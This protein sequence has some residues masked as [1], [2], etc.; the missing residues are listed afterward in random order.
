V[1]TLNPLES[2]K[3]TIDN[4]HGWAIE[5]GH[6][7]STNSSGRISSNTT[8]TN[9]TQPVIAEVKF[10]VSI[11]AASGF[12]ANGWHDGALSG[13]G[14]LPHPPAPNLHYYRVGAAWVGPYN[15]YTGDYVNNWAHSLLSL[16]G[17]GDA[18]AVIQRYPDKYSSETRNAA[19]SITDLPIA[20]GARYDNAAPNQSHDTSWDWVFVR[21]Y[22]A[23]EPVITPG[24]ED[25]SNGLCPGCFDK[26]ITVDNSRGSAQTAFQI[27]VE[28]D[29]DHATFW[30][31][32]TR[33]GDDI[34]F[35]DGETE[36]DYWIEA[37][38]S[39]SGTIVQVATGEYFSCALFNSGE[40]SCWGYNGQGQL[41]DGTTTNRASAVTVQTGET[42]TGNLK[43]VDS[44]S[45]NNRHACA[46]LN[47][48]GNVVC[49]GY[50]NQGQLG[51]NTTTSHSTP[52]Y[53]RSANGQ[54]RLS[55]IV[56]VSVGQ[57]HTCA[58]DGVRQVYCWGDDYLS[59][60]GNGDTNANDELYPVKV[61]DTEDIEEDGDG[62]LNTAID[63]KAGAS[64]T[65]AVLN[66]GK[67]VCWGYDDYEGL[68][69]N[70]TCGSDPDRACLVLNGEHGFIDITAGSSFSCGV[71]PDGGVIYWGNNDNGKLGDGTD[72]DRALAIPMARRIE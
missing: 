5:G 51:N 10:R 34:R 49:W 36:L 48:D 45:A 15:T 55:N 52:V 62:V 39:M 56:K 11:L 43:D 30:D 72:T 65:C 26:A 71:R 23:D 17:A 6:L 41:G 13:F 12:M 21:K 2:G 4:P 63:V 33:G 16:D 54:G 69:D 25:V 50:N 42:G 29:A 44:I 24:T 19:Y 38:G 32:V 64:H 61:V 37:T 47:P 22:A 8:F 20:L 31:N 58:I 9:S 3:W 40:V 53:V 27:K 7:R 67:T 59:R 14:L 35:Y 28:L 18:T 70:G 1:N 46:V 66:S 68:G 60:C 57:W